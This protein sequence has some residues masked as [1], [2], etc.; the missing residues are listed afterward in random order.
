MVARFFLGN[1]YSQRR[2]SAAARPY[3][4][5]TLVALIVRATSIYIA[6]SNKF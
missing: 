4:D 3:A 2:L 6:L 5:P 1:S